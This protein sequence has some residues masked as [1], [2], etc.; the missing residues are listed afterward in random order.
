MLK[1]CYSCVYWKVASKKIPIDVKKK[2]LK[3]EFLEV[4]FE[5]VSVRI[6]AWDWE[7]TKPIR[8]SE[9]LRKRLCL[10]GK[11]I[12]EPWDECENYKPKSEDKKTICQIDTV[13]CEYADICPKSPSRKI[14]T[15]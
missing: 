13:K 4:S 5:N 9:I 7:T 6:P 14:Y 10:Y 1:C 15:I 8:L 12:V 11:G 3:N 2:P